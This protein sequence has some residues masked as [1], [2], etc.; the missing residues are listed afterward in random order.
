MKRVGNLDV[1]VGTLDRHYNQT[2]IALTSAVKAARLSI[3]VENTGRLNST[4][5][6]RNEWK[7]IQS[8]DARRCGVDGLGDLSAFDGT[9]SG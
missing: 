1:L 5:G 6:M 2:T 4:R 7:G 8:R 3:L 9:C